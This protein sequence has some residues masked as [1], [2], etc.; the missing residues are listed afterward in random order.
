MRT[1]GAAC[2]GLGLL[3]SL[4]AVG[5]LGVPGPY[6]DEVIQALPS[7]EFLEG[8]PRALA[9][10][11]SEVLRL[12]GRPFPWMT[13]AYMGALKSQLLIPSFAVAGS[14]LSVLRLTTLAWS[15]LGLLACV[16]FARRVFG[17]GVALVAGLLVVCDPSFLFLSRHD[18]GSFSLGFLLRCASL[19]FAAAWWE[20]GRLRHA[21]LAGATLGLGI[22]N[23]VDFALFP[24]AAVLALLAAD[25]EAVLRVVRERRAH[26]VAA[27]LTAALVALPVL[28]SLPELE[29][30]AGRLAEEVTFS[31]KA[32]ALGSV[33]DGSYFLRL[34]RVGGRFDAMF[35]AGRDTAGRSR[36]RPPADGR[37]A[38]GER[39]AP[40]RSAG[41]R[42]PSR[43]RHL[44]GGP[45]PA[46]SRRGAGAPPDEPLP[47][48]PL[49]RGRRSRRAVAT[50]G[51][52]T[53][54]GA[55]PSG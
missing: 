6:Y 21:L 40:A 16:A 36:H 32:R 24:A 28:A 55:H 13:Q 26:A 30:A 10:P 18:W 47:L 42:P 46:A 12:Q 14:D 35:S 53:P 41:H 39:R 49:D 52:P 9:L 11:G 3:M 8:R 27:I 37:G 43:L 33:L 1:I 34:M 5:D 7:L 54:T 44:A 22:Y 25:R 45:P 50:V 17:S 31:E 29:A 51:T 19:L 4:L 38:R 15:A 23:K 48:S 2:L 20:S